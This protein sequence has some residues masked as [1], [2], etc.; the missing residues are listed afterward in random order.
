[1]GIKKELS[2]EQIEYVIRAYTED[3]KSMTRIGEELDPPVSR[4]V[5][6]RI[7]TEN[8]IKIKTDNH[9]YKADYQKFK[10]IDSVEKAYWLGFIAADGCV[11]T[12][13]KNSTIRIQLSVID[14]TH[15]EK[16]RNFM[17]SD[18]KIIDI[19]Q[20]TGYASKEKPSFMAA[21]AFNSNEM[22]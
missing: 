9:K 16:F 22:A 11:Y 3:G 4:T 12:R 17:N 8:N 14:K 15:L 2:K 1:M 5:I 6:R 7:L 13:E 18:V 19:V 21:I 10:N 20:T